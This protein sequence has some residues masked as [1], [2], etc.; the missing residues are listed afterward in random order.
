MTI[1]NAIL[2]GVGFG[3]G[4]SLWNGVVSF[5]RWAGDHIHFGHS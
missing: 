5:L 2:T 4:L 1:V 3:I